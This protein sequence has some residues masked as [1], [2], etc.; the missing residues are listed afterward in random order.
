[1]LLHIKFKKLT[2][3]YFEILKKNYKIPLII[4]LI[5][6]LLRSY[7]ISEYLF[8]GYEQG[9]D[10][11]I[12]QNLYNFKDFVLV[13]PPSSIG[14]A[15]HGPWYYY[16]MALPYG[17]N[18]G[19]PLAA[20][21]FICILGS[22]VPVLIYIFAKDLFKSRNFGLLTAIVSIFSYEYI[23]YSRWLSNVSPSVPFIVLAFY[24]LWQYSKSKKNIY[25]VLSIFFSIFASLFEV[26]LL[27]QFLFVYI[28]LFIFRVIRF[29]SFK[30]LALAILVGVILFSPL[31]LFDFRNQHITFNSLTAF[32]FSHSSGNF[33]TSYVDLLKI[34]F[35]QSSFVFE[36]A[37]LNTNNIFLKGMLALVMIFGLLTAYLKDRKIALFL[38]AWSLM[39]LPIFLI[40]PGNSHYYFAAAL[41][42]IFVLT[43]TIKIL[44]NYTKLRLLGIL[45]LGLLGF[46]FFN[47]LSK[48]HFNKDVF[49]VTIQDDLNFKDQ[50]AILDYI[51]QDSKNNSYRFESFT[52]P[53]LHPEGWQYLHD[54]YYPNDKSV[55]AK[56]V[57]LTIE[58]KVYPVWEEK[59]TS[60]LGKSHFVWEK[61]FGKI[62]LQKRELE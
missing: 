57:Y 35:V 58:S 33:R 53:S 11:Q 4:F 39:A 51:H 44:L 6:F 25:F 1:M 29:P 34:F 60:D 10:A 5:A 49:Y 55:N 50:R 21:F 45:I 59:W 54:Y 18:G 30:S 9:R 26:L 15:F 31:I 56:I 7:R 38:T 28:L 24:T 19:N 22:L 17:L 32:L 52:I 14:G 16:L 2:K 41:G 40:S 43:L 20:A 3:K 61:K 13:G 8:F 23:L 48:L 36:R 47:S 37:I 62:R 12:I 46:S 42:W 27:V